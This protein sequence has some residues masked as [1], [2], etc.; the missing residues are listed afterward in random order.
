M[1]YTTETEVPLIDNSSP[2]GQTSKKSIEALKKSLTL[3]ISKTPSDITNTHSPEVRQ[4]KLQQAKEEFFKSSP[5]SAPPA[6]EYNE[7]NFP[8]RNRLSQISFESE[9]SYDVVLPGKYYIYIINYLIG[10]L[11]KASLYFL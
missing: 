7:L 8:T 11:E 9:S 3:N 1:T 5:L 6:M 2:S 4:K 10:Y